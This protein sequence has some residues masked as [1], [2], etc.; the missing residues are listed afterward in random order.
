M[1]EPKPSAGTRRKR[2]AIGL[3]IAGMLLTASC[4][5]GL[6]I[7]LLIAVVL[8][9]I[10]T[11]MTYLS[12]QRLRSIVSG[13]ELRALIQVILAQG[14]SDLPD[15]IA[16]LLKLIEKALYKEETAKQLPGLI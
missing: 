5:K 1:F 14:S 12:G 2:L 11:L 13:E 4:A 7:G 6:L 9:A 16:K 10:I 8:A 3:L 15:D